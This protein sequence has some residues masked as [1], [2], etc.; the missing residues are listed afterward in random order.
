MTRP[1]LLIFHRPAGAGEPPL[2][3]FLAEVRAELA[4][5]Q[6]A[7]LERAGAAA[8]TFVDEWYED[9]AFGEVIRRLAP[10]RGGV[11]VLGSGAV[12]RLNLADARRLVAVAASGRAE[13][14]T[15]NR[16]SS[17]IVALGR[18][19]VLRKTPAL[20]SDNALPRWLQELAGIRVD[21]LAGRERLALGLDTP[22][23]A[24]L[25]AL[26]PGAP[27][28][29]RRAVDEA[30]RAVPRLADLRAVARD[31]LRELLVFGRSGSRTLAWLERNVRC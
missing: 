8:P 5:Q 18:A 3:R 13:A 22:L 6:A 30:G 2:V 31:P 16:Y 15:N 24:C 11:I 27:A 10:A 19:S 17:D 28:W 7:L 12:A 29:L 9:L 20:P 23:D 14:L 25:A 4:R 26:A 21:E 1:A